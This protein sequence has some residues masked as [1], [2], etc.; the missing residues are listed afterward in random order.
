MY[1]N[2]QTDDTKQNNNIKFNA[3]MHMVNNGKHCGKLNFVN[4]SYDR[5]LIYVQTSDEKGMSN[6]T[7]NLNTKSLRKNVTDCDTKC[8]NYSFEKCK[9]H[10]STNRKFIGIINFNAQGIFEG[11]HFDQIIIYTKELNADIIAISES[12]L[13]KSISNGILIIIRYLEAIEITRA[14]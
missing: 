10:F 4:D 11:T 14:R 12:W 13:N 7:D 3:T 5:S 2:E 9:A 8:S 6:E 1:I